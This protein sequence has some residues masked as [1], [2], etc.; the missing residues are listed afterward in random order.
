MADERAARTAVEKGPRW[1]VCWV[2][3]S[4]AGTADLSAV[5]TV[6]LKVGQMACERV[7]PKAVLK[8]SNW[9]VRWVAPSDGLMAD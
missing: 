5:S 7:A 2:I 6:E 3:L 9:V 4:V 8:G 1:V